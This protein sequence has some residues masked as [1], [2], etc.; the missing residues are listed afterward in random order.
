MWQKSRKDATYASEKKRLEHLNS[1]RTENQGV[2]KMVR[3]NKSKK[4]SIDAINAADKQTAA[5]WGF[6]EGHPNFYLDAYEL[7]SLRR[8][9]L[10]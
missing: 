2:V 1:H 7:E 10:H 9:V 5:F 8:V 6:I 3:D 4:L